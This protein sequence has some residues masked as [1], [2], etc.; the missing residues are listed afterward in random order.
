MIVRIITHLY[1]NQGIAYSFPHV[2]IPILCSV[3]S[4]HKPL[5]LHSHFM[6]Q[7]DQLS[8]EQIAGEWRDWLS[9]C[10]GFNCIHANLYMHY[11]SEQI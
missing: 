9:L 7:A 5:C 8:E 2:H 1:V 10:F 11:I 3:V 4:V 6:L